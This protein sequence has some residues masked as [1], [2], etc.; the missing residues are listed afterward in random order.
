MYIAYTN[1]L[2]INRLLYYHQSSLGA[3]QVSLSN[4]N[5]A[6][7]QLFGSGV[8]IPIDGLFDQ[9]VLQLTICTIYDFVVPKPTV[10][11]NSVGTLNSLGFLSQL[12]G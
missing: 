8:A 9:N 5:Q 12:V 4:L 3:V 1:I 7:H 10:D 6:W 11:N 2:H